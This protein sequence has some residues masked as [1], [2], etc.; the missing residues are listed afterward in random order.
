M[1][2][3]IKFNGKYYWVA[4]G[5]GQVDLASVTEKDNTITVKDN[6]GK[7]LVLTRIGEDKLKVQSCDAEFATI[8]KFPKDTVFTYTKG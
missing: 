4:R 1:Y 5:T 2:P 8:G 3:C 7:K 6:F